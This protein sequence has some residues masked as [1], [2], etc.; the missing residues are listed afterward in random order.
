MNFKIFLLMVI[1]LPMLLVKEA[2][3]IVVVAVLILEGIIVDKHVYKHV[4]VTRAAYILN[5]NKI[6]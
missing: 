1:V 4:M 5:K 3:E 6:L 2:V